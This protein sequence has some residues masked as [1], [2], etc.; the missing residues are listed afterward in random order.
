ML[1][2]LK[3]D[4]LGYFDVSEDGGIVFT[5]ELD[6]AYRFPH[7]TSAENI[8]RKV[9]PDVPVTVLPVPARDK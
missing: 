7:P 6:K 1:Y 8:A 2:V 5:W 9:I 4:L 3:N